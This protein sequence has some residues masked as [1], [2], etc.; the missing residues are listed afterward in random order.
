MNRTGWRKY[1]V[2]VL[3]LWTLVDLSFPVLCGSEEISFPDQNAGVTL[4]AS[5]YHAPDTEP[6]KYNSDNDCFCC[7]SHIVPS[8]YFALPA[9]FQSVSKDF[10]RPIG[11]PRGLSRSFYHPPR[12]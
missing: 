8:P 10:P 9:D 12:A 3:L 5:A 1:V 7:C 6:S 2:Y 11:E 4:S